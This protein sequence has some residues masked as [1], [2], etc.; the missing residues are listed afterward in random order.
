MVVTG[1][2]EAPMVMVALE[3]EDENGGS[4][5]ERR[6]QQCRGSEVVSEREEALLVARLWRT[7]VR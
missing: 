1:D 3:V 6:Q 4:G 7:A 5:G 2:D